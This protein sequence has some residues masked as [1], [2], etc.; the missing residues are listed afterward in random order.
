MQKAS[1]ISVDPF[2]AK[3]HMF[4]VIFST[5]Q[6][7]FDVQLKLYITKHQQNYKGLS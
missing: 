3:S 7:F 5:N 4:L 6:G 2:P 1:A